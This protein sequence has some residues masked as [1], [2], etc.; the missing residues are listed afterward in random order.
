MTVGAQTDPGDLDLAALKRTLADADGLQPVGLGQFIEGNGVLHQL[1]E[2]VAR[3]QPRAQIVVLA[4]A[5]PMLAAGQDLRQVI[6][7]ALGNR[8]DLQWCVIGAGLDVHADAETVS[9]ATAALSRADCAITVGSGTITDIGKAA[10]H[11][12]AGDGRAMPLVCVQT[13]TSVNGFAD[14]FSVLLRD[15]VKR[16]TASRTVWPTP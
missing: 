3:L 14:P 7:T 5:T 2:F 13:A 8:H 12:A 10:V 4:A 6:E 11:A 1:P 15:G 9:T 16:T